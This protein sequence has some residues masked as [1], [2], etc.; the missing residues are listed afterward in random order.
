MWLH[1]HGCYDTADCTRLEPARPM[2]LPKIKLSA[3][4]K[5]HSFS[6]K[7][8]FPF[9]LPVKSPQSPEGEA[10]FCKKT[11]WMRVT[12]FVELLL[13]LDQHFLTVRKWQK[14]FL[15]DYDWVLV[16]HAAAHS[17][18]EPETGELVFPA[19]WWTNTS[20]TPRCTNTIWPTTVSFSACWTKWRHGRTGNTNKLNLWFIGF[21][22]HEVVFVHT[23]PQGGKQQKRHENTLFI[24]LHASGCDTWGHMTRSLTSENGMCCLVGRDRISFFFKQVIEEKNI[25]ILDSKRQRNGD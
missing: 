18:L 14:W 6:Y 17:A 16:P 10:H 4:W 23:Y 2:W 5:F 8:I 1:L 3:L 25:T 9:A 21:D 15:D 12:S 7:M 24:H 13:G 20:P 11:G 19:L 22:S